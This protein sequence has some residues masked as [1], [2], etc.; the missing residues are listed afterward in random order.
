MDR[1]LYEIQEWLLQGVI[2]LY[3]TRRRDDATITRMDK[4]AHA[5]KC[6]EC[7]LKNKEEDY[8][9]SYADESYSGRRDSRGRYTSHDG[10]DS[11]AMARLEHYAMNGNEQER[12]LANRM[13]DEIRRG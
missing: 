1:K 7:F 12:R 13:L 6:L 2:N 9:Y 5:A 3:E 8:S 4:M 11:Y 10:Q